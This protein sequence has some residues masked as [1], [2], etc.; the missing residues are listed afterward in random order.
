MEVWDSADGMETLITEQT[1][2]DKQ[3]RRRKEESDDD[4]EE[5]IVQ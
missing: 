3:I 1:V 5:I 4:I 2:E